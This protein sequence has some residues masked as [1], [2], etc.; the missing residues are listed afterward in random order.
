VFVGILDVD[1][2]LPADVRSLKDKRSHVRGLVA[3][4]RRRYDVAAAEAGHLDLHRR[5]LVGVAVVGA[6]LGHCREVLDAC[7]RLV[8]SRPELELLAARQRFVGD[9]DE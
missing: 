3:E 2:L 1:V 8:A 4:L 9:H 7:E 6:D 5:T